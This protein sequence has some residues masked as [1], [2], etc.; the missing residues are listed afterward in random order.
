M[1][2][3]TAPGGHELEGD[4]WRMI[5]RAPKGEDAYASLFNEVSGGGKLS[6][7]ALHFQPPR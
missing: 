3:K 5:G 2:G 6:P 7:Q 1:E 4:W